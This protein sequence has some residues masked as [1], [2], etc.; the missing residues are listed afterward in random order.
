MS[1]LLSFHL[2]FI[3]KLCAQSKAICVCEYSMCVC[4]CYSNVH[5]IDVI[6]G[7]YISLTPA[8]PGGVYLK[9][10]EIPQE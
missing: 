10:A 1:V 4:N 9:I 3:G 6:V 5:I 8:Q 2:K 7:T